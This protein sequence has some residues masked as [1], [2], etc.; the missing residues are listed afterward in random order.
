M[1]GDPHDAARLVGL[2]LRAARACGLLPIRPDVALGAAAGLRTAVRRRALDAPLLRL[3]R[4]LA[5]S[6]TPEH[7][8]AAAALAEAVDA[9]DYRAALALPRTAGRRADLG[10]EKILSRRHRFLWLC[11]PKVASRSIIAALRAADPGARL[12]RRRSLDEILA[13]HPEARG[14]FRFAFLRHPVERARSCHA[15]KHAL[16]RTDAAARRWFVE[17]YH[18]LS[19]GMT[20]AEFCRWLDTPW[21]C[22]AFADRHWLSQ[23]RQVR[24]GDGRLPDFLGRWE[25]LDADWRAVCGRLGLPHRALPRLNVRPAGTGTEPPDNAATAL[26]GGRYAADFRLGGYDGTGPR[27]G[28]RLAP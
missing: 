10:A 26:L 3:S 9:A 14:Y 2:A 24:D 20:F 22:D 12:I 4:R 19:L 1:T 15:D 13:R 18:G 6:P 23:H 11:V 25:T 5:A 27:G 7:A 17:P 8:A 21:G 28:R 16:A